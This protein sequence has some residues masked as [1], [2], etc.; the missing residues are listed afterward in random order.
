M[1][2]GALIQTNGYWIVALGCVVE[3]ETLLALAGFAAH[4]GYLQLPAVIAVAAVTAFAGDQAF[5][6]LGR[7]HGTWVLQRYPGMAARAQHVQR[8][9]ERRGV[10]VIVLVRFAYGLRTAGPIVIGTSRVGA[11]RFALF[12]GLGA[13]LWAATI[14]SLGWTFGTAVE[15]TF[16]KIHRFGLW[17]IGILAAGALL[18]W[19]GRR[20]IRRPISR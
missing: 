9:I 16:G 7:T 5:F 17:A 10:L 3:G 11:V 15:A 8:W 1:D 19:I 18:W 13:I 6:W 14:A 20:L 4:E 12:N 2:L